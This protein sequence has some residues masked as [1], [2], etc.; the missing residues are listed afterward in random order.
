MAS[1]TILLFI[2]T[3]RKVAT[4]FN[5]WL[6]SFF[7]AFNLKGLPWEF[8]AFYSNSAHAST[9][10]AVA[11]SFAAFLIPPIMQIYSTAKIAKMSL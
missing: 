2:G 8:D 9:I 3:N 1:H 4:C 10:G 7:G 6:L 5:D 11:A